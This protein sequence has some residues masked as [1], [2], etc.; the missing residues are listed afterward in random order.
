LLKV[1]IAGAFVAA[2]LGVISI[3]QVAKA[4]AWFEHPFGSVY[5]LYAQQNP[6]QACQNVYNNLNSG[7]AYYQDYRGI[8]IGVT[9]KTA[10]DGYD[11]TSGVSN[12]WRNGNGIC[13]ANKFQ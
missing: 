2:T 9:K 3:A 12:I 6:S 11:I 1:K 4:Y 10:T 7:I 5:G 8:W 13:I